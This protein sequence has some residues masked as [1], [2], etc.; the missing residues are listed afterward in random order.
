MIN[1]RGWLVVLLYIAAIMFG[2]WLGARDGYAADAGTNSPS[3][4]RDVIAT[5]AAA[6]PRQTERDARAAGASEA[7]IEAAKKCLRDFKARD[8]SQK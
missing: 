8:K 4:C 6:G 1:S 5:V 7:T 3:F 2:L